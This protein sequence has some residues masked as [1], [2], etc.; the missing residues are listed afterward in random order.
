MPSSYSVQTVLAIVR[1]P[2]CPLLSLGK[3]D[4]RVEFDGRVEP[5][6]PPLR[7][8]TESRSRIAPVERE[9]PMPLAFQALA[10]RAADQA[11]RAG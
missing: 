3:I 8:I 2:R 5:D 10:E 4:D 6:F 7:R 1:I 11:G 9:Y